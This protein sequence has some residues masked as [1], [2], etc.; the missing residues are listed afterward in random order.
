MVMLTFFIN[1]V[2]L[3]NKILCFVSLNDLLA[4]NYMLAY[5]NK[6]LVSKVLAT[7]IFSQLAP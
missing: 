1:L 2:F 6:F 5:I 3:L 4:N 7:D